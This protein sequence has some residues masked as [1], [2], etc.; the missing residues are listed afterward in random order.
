MYPDPMLYK[1]KLRPSDLEQI[2]HLKLRKAD[3]EEATASSGLDPISTLLL[4]IELSTW[5]EVILNQHDEI[6][7]VFGL[8]A[9]QGVPW[10]MATD[11]LVKNQYTLIKMAREVVAEMLEECPLL[12]NYVDGRN[13]KHI[14]WLKW[15]G[16]KFPGVTA[17]LNGVKFH[18]FMK[19]RT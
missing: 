15:M 13:T 6:I 19:E 9:E 2:K 5:T 1:R 18:Q 3:Q 14:E 12:W 17:M 7:V 11:E 4:S 16:F 10:L 8:E